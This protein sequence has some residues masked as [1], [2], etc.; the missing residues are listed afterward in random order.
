[1][2]RSYTP[3]GDMHTVPPLDAPIMSPTVSGSVSI[4]APAAKSS[5]PI[6]STNTTYL[7]LD[8]APAR[9]NPNANIR[10]VTPHVLSDYVVAKETQ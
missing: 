1:M 10:S 3:P 8:I 4:P 6:R 7:K 9:M 5:T 2:H